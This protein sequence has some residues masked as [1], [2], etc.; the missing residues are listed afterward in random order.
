MKLV[1]AGCFLHYHQIK[2]PFIG[3]SCSALCLNPER[4][5]ENLGI[6][7]RA[8]TDL[9]PSMQPQVGSAAISCHT[10]LS[11]PIISKKP[12]LCLCISLIGGSCSLS[13]WHLIKSQKAGAGN[14]MMSQ[15]TEI[16]C[17]LSKEILDWFNGGWKG[18]SIHGRMLFT[19]GCS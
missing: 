8:G 13:C 11:K 7:L 17:H 9:T 14:D 19:L 3:T 10:K 15:T 4:R 2:L 12:F 16:Q 18:H 1:A 5:V 6:Q